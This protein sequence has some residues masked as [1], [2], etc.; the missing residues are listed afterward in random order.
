[1]EVA[2]VVQ[3][4][5]PETGWSIL[6]EACMAIR[7]GAVWVACNADP[8]LPTERGQLPGNGSMVA[9]LRAA[10]GASPE[11]AGKPEPGLFSGAVLEAGARRAL[12]V[13]DRLDTD[14][15]GASA[16]GLDSLLVLSGVTTPAELL[17]AP[18][19]F[20]PH[21]LGADMSALSDP[22]GALEIG[23]RP[24]WHVATADGVLRIGTDGTG[25][26]PLELVRALCAP[27]WAS[28]VSLIEPADERA[29]VVARSLG[30][31]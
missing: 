23:D 12:V 6:A 24:G 25:A 29:R 11:V 22:P 26:E 17:A 31:L 20:R 7:A 15:A 10:T 21:Y 27:A 8:T 13:G 28:G 18:P 5:S 1:P 9:A 16:A 19:G 14:I 2:A 30:L 3:G 4:H